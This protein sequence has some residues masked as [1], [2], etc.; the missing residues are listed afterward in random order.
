NGE[1]L[2]ADRY[3]RLTEVSVEQSLHLPSMC[4]I[5]LHDIGSQPSRATFFQLLD[6]DA[7]PIG[8]ELEVSLGREGPAEVVF[9]GEITA[10]ELEAS[11]ERMPRIVVR[12]YDRAHRL[13]RGRHS[14]SFV[15]MA[16]SDIVSKLA[17]E[18]GLSA[19]A[20]STN[21]VHDYVFQYNQTNWEFLRQRAAL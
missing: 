5:R 6:Q 16:D 14:R 15:Q 8:A 19:Q 1:N 4:T 17:T 12:A 10:V 13:M 7:L 20:E 11:T 9:K 2:S 21:P 18:V 3:A